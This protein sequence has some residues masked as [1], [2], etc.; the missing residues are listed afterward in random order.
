[1]NA[2]SIGLLKS[3]LLGGAAAG[4]ACWVFLPHMLKGLDKISQRLKEPSNASAIAMTSTSPLSAASTGPRCRTAV[5]AD[6]RCLVP[7][8]YRQD[9]W[10]A[11]MGTTWHVYGT[12]TYGTNGGD[13]TVTEGP[14]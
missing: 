1:M 11:A 6:G 8:T 13:V 12:V 5:A 3:A 7:G 4:L 2:S 9:A 10:R 14:P